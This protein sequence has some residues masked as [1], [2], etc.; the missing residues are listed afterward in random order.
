MLPRLRAEETL[1]ASVSVALGSGS[2]GKEGA[3]RVQRD[4]QSQAG[5]IRRRKGGSPDFAALVEMGINVE[6]V[7]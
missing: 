5:I 3:A 1:D 4:L 7:G 2:Y 6:V